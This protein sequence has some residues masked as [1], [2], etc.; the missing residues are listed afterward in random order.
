MY[1]CSC[2]VSYWPSVKSVLLSLQNGNG[3]LQSVQVLYWRCFCSSRHSSNES[4]SGYTGHRVIFIPGSHPLILSNTQQI[5][6]PRF[7]PGPRAHYAYHPTLSSTISLTESEHRAALDR[8]QCRVRS[9]W[10]FETFSNMILSLKRLL[11]EWNYQFMCKLGH[12]V[13]YIV[14]LSNESDKL[15][16]LSDTL[17]FRWDH[18]SNVEECWSWTQWRNGR[19]SRCWAPL[20]HTSTPTTVTQHHSTARHTNR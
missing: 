19:L 20:P 3:W 7:L 1:I 18:F 16:V 2:Q 17:S 5:K 10:L 4:S 9:L 13:I 14:S 8:D 15:A 12:Y 6:F 11:R